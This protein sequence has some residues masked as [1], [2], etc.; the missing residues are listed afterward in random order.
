MQVVLTDDI[1]FLKFFLQIWTVLG[2]CTPDML[3][4]N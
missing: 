3:L 1:A 2:V 4:V